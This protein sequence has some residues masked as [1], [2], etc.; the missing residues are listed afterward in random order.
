MSHD[1][2]V[3]TT[4]LLTHFH[5][6]RRRAVLESPAVDNTENHSRHPD[7]LQ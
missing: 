3:T 2:G 4:E 1:G 6:L 7:S 5:L